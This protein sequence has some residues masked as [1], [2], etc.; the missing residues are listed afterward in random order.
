MKIGT[1]FWILMIIVFFVGVFHY[2]MP[3]N[4]S[5]SMGSDAVVFVLF[6]LLGWKCFGFV[7]QE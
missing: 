2:N 1:I 7:V 3:N 5:L 6:F 4:P